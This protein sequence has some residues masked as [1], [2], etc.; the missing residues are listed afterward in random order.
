MYIFHVCLC[1]SRNSGLQN[2]CFLSHP[3][4]MRTFI[5]FSFGKLSVLCQRVSSLTMARPLLCKTKYDLLST[6]KFTQSKFIMIHL[7]H[8]GKSIYAHLGNSFNS[9][10]ETKRGKYREKYTEKNIQESHT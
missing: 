9:S 4:K 10:K 5:F 6:S 2:M 8:E 3:R 1:N 7:N